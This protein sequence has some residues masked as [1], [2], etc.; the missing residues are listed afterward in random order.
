M[1][2]PRVVLAE[3]HAAMA[4][5]LRALLIPDYDVV[6]ARDGLALIDAVEASPPDVIVSDLAMPGISGLAAAQS[7]LARHPGARI[8]FVT[9]E[10]EPA[11]IRKAISIGALGYVLKCDAG[12]E[13]A[14]AVRSALGGSQYLSVTSRAV[15]KSKPR[16]S[17][18]RPVD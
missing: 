10:D 4:Q 14:N 8:V 7:I 9:V 18:A 11:V 13:L 15:L 12:E 17:G 16:A 3:D 6:I 5:Q 2:C 1:A